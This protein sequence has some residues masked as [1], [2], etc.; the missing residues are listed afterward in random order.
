MLPYSLL[1]L[2]PINQGGSVA[3]ALN[4]S[5]RMAVLAE[6]CAYQR[7]WLAEHHG[8]QGVASSATAL[9][10]GHIASATKNIHAC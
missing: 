5:R 7:V 6:Q 3:Q 1:D 10:I 8:M 9:V 2:A 4:N